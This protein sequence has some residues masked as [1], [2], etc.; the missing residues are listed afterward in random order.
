MNKHRDE[1]ELW[2]LR[3]EVCGDPQAM[4]CSHTPGDYFE[5]KGE[6][7][8]FSGKQSFSL[9]AMAAILPLLPAKQRALAEDDWLREEAH[10]I[11]SD[12]AGNVDPDTSDDTWDWT[13]DTTPPETDI[14]GSCDA[15]LTAADSFAPAT[16][17]TTA[18]VVTM[19]SM[20]P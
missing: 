4:V 15:T 12:P 14:D 8:C 18:K 2:D 13:V 1:F 17:L 3:V 9:Y 16:P 5:V 19:P 11:C 7:L 6:N 10:A 20:A